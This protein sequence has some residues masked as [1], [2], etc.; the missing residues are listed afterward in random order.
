SD[1]M[2]FIASQL[3]E[4]GIQTEIRALSPT[5]AQPLYNA[6]EVTGGLQSWG[7]LTM[8][9]MSWEGIAYGNSETGEWGRQNHGR[10]SS[11]RINALLDDLGNETDR[12]RREQLF[13]ELAQA[14]MDEIPV[15]P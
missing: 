4:I 7:A 3:A 14:F 10:F 6:H 5:V 2:L 9:G 15:I 13:D 11:Q 1:T 8:P 12:D